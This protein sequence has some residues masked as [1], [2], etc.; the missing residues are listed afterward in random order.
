VQPTLRY[1]W[2]TTPICSLIALNLF[3]HYYFVCTVS[4]GFVDDSPRQLGTGI[5]WAVARTGSSSQ[6]RNGIGW[7]G[8]SVE[9]SEELNI[10][11]ASV[12]KCKRCGQMRPE[13]RGSCCVHRLGCLTSPERS[14]HCRVC[15]RCVL[16]YDHHCPVSLGIFSSLFIS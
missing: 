7:R 2:I 11:K 16:K 8:S 14:H 3:A 4:P 6:S 13:V 9:W 15:N 5:F 10:T 12:T 1:P